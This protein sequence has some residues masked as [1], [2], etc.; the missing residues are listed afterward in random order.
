[1]SPEEL[2]A[3]IE[4]TRASVA[5]ASADDRPWLVCQLADLCAAARDA[6]SAEGDSRA[7]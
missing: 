2:R 5:M 4:S 3:A 1:M 7:S 6:E